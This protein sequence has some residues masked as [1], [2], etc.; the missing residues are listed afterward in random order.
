MLVNA[1]CTDAACVARSPR[2]TGSVATH[3]C[4]H[5]LC[6]AA[7]AC[8]HMSSCVKM[9]CRRSGVAKTALRAAAFASEAAASVRRLVCIDRGGSGER[10]VI[11]ARLFLWRSFRSVG[12]LTVYT[13]R[14]APQQTR[15][16]RIC[17]RLLHTR[18]KVGVGM[19]R[20]HHIQAPT[21]LAQHAA[22]IGR[23]RWSARDRTPG[24]RPRRRSIDIFARRDCSTVTWWQCFCGSR[25]AL[26]AGGNLFCVL[27]L[28]NQR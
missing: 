3:A 11:C 8:S 18:F 21:G 9:I 1:G 10:G 5:E 17:R 22:D 26:D 28:R 15:C 23:R 24:P 2:R 20:I 25:V 7:A 14:R 19:K 27:L 16:R 4:F 6:A 12:V 13:V